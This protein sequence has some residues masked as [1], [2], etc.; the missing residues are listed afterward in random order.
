MATLVARGEPSR[1]VFAAVAQ[2][3]GR[4]LPADLTLI[5][6]YEDDV[7]TGAGGWSAT[8]EPVP[9]RGRVSLGGRNVSD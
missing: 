5:G 1:G 6:R 4:L 3:V 7:Q 9:I 2:E 8:G